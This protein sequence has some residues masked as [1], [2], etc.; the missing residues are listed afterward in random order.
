MWFKAAAT[1]QSQRVSKLLKVRDIS[2]KTPQIKI[3]G[4][5]SF[6]ANAL[7]KTCM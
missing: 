4:Q 1:K 6:V 3:L 5:K 7:A 2:Y